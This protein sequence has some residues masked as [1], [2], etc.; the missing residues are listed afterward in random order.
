MRR[1]EYCVG[2]T[3]VHMGVKLAPKCRKFLLVPT[4]DMCIAL[5]KSDVR[6]RRCEY[7]VGDTHV[8]MGVNLAPKCRKFLLV[9][10]ADMCIAYVRVMSVSVDVS[11]ASGILM[12]IWGQL[13]TKVSPAF[14]S[15]RTIRSGLV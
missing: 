5:R 11:I 6:K 4:A 14:I 15:P 8:H 10:T 9:P 3:D 2:N 1:C 12:F 13:S 7:C